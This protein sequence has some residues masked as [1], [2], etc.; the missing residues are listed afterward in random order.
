[1]IPRIHNDELNGTQHLSSKLGVGRTNVLSMI[2]NIPQGIPTV[3]QH[4]MKKNEQ[5]WSPDG[6]F[7][8]IIVRSLG[9]Q[10][11]LKES[12]QERQEET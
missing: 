3:H 8:C 12:K 11:F 6:I 1:M 9:L 5:K 7:L 10:I 2:N 4:C